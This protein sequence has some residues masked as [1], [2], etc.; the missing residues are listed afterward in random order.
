MRKGQMIDLRRRSKVSVQY[1]LA[2]ATRDYAAP[3]N[4]AKSRSSSISLK[5]DVDSLSVCLLVEKE[6]HIG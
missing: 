1:S 4:S 2:A 5:A 3:G 6:T